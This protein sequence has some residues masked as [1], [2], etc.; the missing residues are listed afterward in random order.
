MDGNFDLIC[1]ECE[2][3]FFVTEEGE[4]ASCDSS[5]FLAGCSEC[6]DAFTCT[7]CMNE[8]A[9]I[10]DQVFEFNPNFKIQRQLV[11]TC[12]FRPPPPKR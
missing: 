11:S 2:D 3:G 5:P 10:E 1:D 9:L 8:D 4:C 6:D 7:S 12:V